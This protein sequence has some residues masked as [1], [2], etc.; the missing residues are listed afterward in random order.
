M[1][2]QP[3]KII[4]LIHQGKLGTAFSQLKK[5]HRNISN[6]ELWL[7]LGDICH[8]QGLYDAYLQCCMACLKLNQR[9]AHA[10]SG[11]G[12]AYL[13]KGDPK[14]ALQFTQQAVTFGGNVPEILYT[15]GVV[16]QK[17]DRHDGAVHYFQQSLK[18]DPD[19]AMTH[20]LVG[21]SYQ[22]IGNNELAVLH[23]KKSL[24]YNPRLEK[25]LM[26]LSAHYQTVGDFDK[27]LHFI[28]E[29][30]KVSPKSPSLLSIY[31]NLLTILGEKTEAYKVVRGLIDHDK[32]IPFTLYVYSHLCPKYGEISELI[33]LSKRLINRSGITDADKRMLGYALGK[34]YD[35]EGGY[36]TAFQYYKLANNL[37]PGKYSVE[38]YAALTQEIIDLYDKEYTSSLPKNSEDQNSPIFIIGMP[39]S[40]TTLVEQILSKHS[41]VYAAG[42]LAYIVDIVRN[43]SGTPATNDLHLDLIRQFQ[44]DD[45]KVRADEYM[46]KIDEL[47]GGAERVTDKLPSNYLYLG[48]ISQMFPQAK[49]IHC[50]RDPRDTCLSIYFQDL[51][52]Y[53]AYGNSLNDTAH[54]YHE[55]M[56]LMDHWKDV[57]E[58]PILDVHYEDLVEDLETN[59]ARILDF[60]ELDWE[61]EC[62]EFYL[63]DRKVATSSFDQVKQP[64]YNR[65]AGRW[66]NYKQYLGDLEQILGLL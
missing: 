57:L 2:N 22:L 39:R 28:S 35:S 11:A 46:R 23:Y 6:E 18:L 4:A 21:R 52:N 32:C 63:S 42:E 61:E 53:H 27:A 26:W 60:C 15:A 8:E 12:K 37:H 34:S 7:L 13:D 30:L 20:C 56:R 62:L 17:L 24:K 41:N 31:A 9:N 33:Q 51:G 29:A 50:I 16:L 48:L 65:S 55:Y 14:Q 3:K 45:F 47:S 5:R 25:S 49:I 59:V 36:D 58:I 38:S 10:Y 1:K 44:I 64:I 43:L 19:N 54:V 40:G 66:V